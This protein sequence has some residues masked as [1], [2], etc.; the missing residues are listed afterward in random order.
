MMLFNSCSARELQT[1]GRPEEADA[2]W[3]AQHER[4]AHEMF[5]MLCDLK[6]CALPFFH[7]AHA[8]THRHTH[9]HA[10]INL[11]FCLIGVSCNSSNPPPS[12]WLHA[13]PILAR[14]CVCYSHAHRGVLHVSCRV[15]PLE[16]V[17]LWVHALT[18]KGRLRGP[19][20]AACIKER[21][22]VLKGRAPPHRPRGRA[23]IE[24]Y[25]IKLDNGQKEGG[26]A[27][28]WNYPFWYSPC[29][30]APGNGKGI[31][32]GTARPA[33]TLGLQHGRPL[34]ASACK[35]GNRWRRWHARW[36]RGLEK[37]ACRKGNVRRIKLYL[38]V[39][40]AELK[41]QQQGTGHQ[42]DA[43]LTNA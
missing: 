19:S 11:S 12:C 26:N 31:A 13:S 22:T 29:I 9:S 21:S 15:E 14:I 34:A 8:H 43:V 2:L 16:G 28:H 33:C 36:Q 3:A 27:G 20:L 6:V 30:E 18:K 10:R 25:S 23:S 37:G 35:L 4:G 24:V 32:V 38:L 41:L 40:A 42:Q 7:F 17:S 5:L 1:L 39:H